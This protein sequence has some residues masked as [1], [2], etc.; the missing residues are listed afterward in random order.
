MHVKRSLA[1]KTADEIIDLSLSVAAQNNFNPLTVVIIDSG[2]NPV[3]FKSQDGSGSMRYEVAFGK[4][5]GVIGMGTSS[6]DLGNRMAERPNFSNALSAASGGKFI[7]VPGGVPIL[8]D[9]MI[10]GAVGISGDTSDNDE[11]CA[12]TALKKLGFEIET[13]D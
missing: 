1:L 11:Y 6:R 12:H 5:Y 3:S 7:P 8:R 2:G 13:N 4:A 10:I 9:G